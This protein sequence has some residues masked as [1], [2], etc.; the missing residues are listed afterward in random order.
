MAVLA[1]A[2][3]AMGATSAISSAQGAA[4]SAEAQYQQ[5]MINQRWSE[6]EKEMSITQQRGVM[7]LQEFD[8]LFGNT[9]LETES[10]QNQVFAQRAYREQSQYNTQQLVRASRQAQAR[11]GAS[12]ASRG[13]A[14]GGSAEAITRQSETD[15]MNDLARIKIND[16]NALSG[17][18]AQ[19][20]QMLKQRNMRP[21]TQPPTYI[22]S[23]PVQPPNT[24]GMMAGALL[25]SLASG[26][27][28]L[29]GVFDAGQPGGGTSGGWGGYAQGT[30]QY[31][32]AASMGPQLPSIGG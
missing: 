23:T 16:V 13:M 24:S 31:A 11:Q 15:L 7:G 10:L 5:Q 19:R 3:L 28:G 21:V 27:G 20:N 9:T 25:G 17:I 22:P 18:E 6:F 32:Q 29:A 1:I 26:I 30:P 2:G 14:R 12:M 8:R 4:N